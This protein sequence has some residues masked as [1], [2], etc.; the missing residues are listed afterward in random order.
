MAPVSGDTYGDMF[1]HPI[2]AVPMRFDKFLERARGIEPP[3]R[4]SH[5]ACG[6]EVRGAPSAIALFVLPKKL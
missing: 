2:I 3:L 4:F 6:F 5:E 1:I